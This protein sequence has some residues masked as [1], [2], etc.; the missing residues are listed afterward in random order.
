MLARVF[1]GY[2][3]HAGRCRTE[4]LG[5]IE[6]EEIDTADYRSEISVKRLKASDVIVIVITTSRTA[7]IS[8]EG[9]HNPLETIVDELRSQL[10]RAYRSC[11]ATR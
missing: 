9:A 2:A 11:N 8:T 4:D 10:E 7:G 6:Q 5:V 3:Q 1:V